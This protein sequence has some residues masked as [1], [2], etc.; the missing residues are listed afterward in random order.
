MLAAA[1]FVPTEQVGDAVPGIPLVAQDGRPFSLVRG[2]GKVQ[3][4]TFAY[5]RCGDERACPAASGKFAWLQ[6]HLGNTPIRLV[7]ITIDPAYDT[8]A[9]LRAYGR[10]FGEDPAR[11]T[12]ATGA[13]VEVDELATRLGVV[14]SRSS[15]TVITHTETAIV[16]DADG[17]ITNRI[18]GVN[19]DPLDVL[20]LARS[21]AGDRLSPLAAARLW[22]TTAVASCG[23]GAAGLSGVTMLVILAVV[24]AIASVVVTRAWKAR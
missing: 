14:T 15:P 22:L 3:I 18:D 2:E 24:S 11:W 16:L 17:R 19:W 10:A 5:T 9:V 4:V 23:G 6:R 1:P 12:L 13:P 21:A 7:E 20:A 8:P